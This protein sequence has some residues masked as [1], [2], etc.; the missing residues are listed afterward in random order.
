[1]TVFNW[2]K[3]QFIIDGPAAEFRPVELH[4]K[5][6]GAIGDKPSMVIVLDRSPS[7]PKIYGQ[8]SLETLKEALG[9]L[10]YK[11]LPK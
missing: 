1:M 3:R 2:G 5:S 9:E 8:F 4:Y 11:V 7:D 10:G 6:D